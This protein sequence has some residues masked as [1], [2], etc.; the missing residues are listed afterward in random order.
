VL[1]TFASIDVCVPPHGRR[2]SRPLY[3][4]AELRRIQRKLAGQTRSPRADPMDEKNHLA[5]VR[6]AGSNPVV[7]SK[8]SPGQGIDRPA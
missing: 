5:K 3:N 2:R 7:R 6:V 8:K 4:R 1:M